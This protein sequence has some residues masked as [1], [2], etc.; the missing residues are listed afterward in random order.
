MPNKAVWAAGSRCV[1]SG[2]PTSHHPGRAAVPAVPA[3]EIQA[4]ATRARP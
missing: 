3:D 4:G 2:A 1:A